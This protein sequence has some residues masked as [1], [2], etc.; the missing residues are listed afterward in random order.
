M[1][2]G[3]Q[4]PVLTEAAEHDH[5]CPKVKQEKKKSEGIYFRISIYLVI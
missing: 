4:N 2:T 1:I 5:L 3:D